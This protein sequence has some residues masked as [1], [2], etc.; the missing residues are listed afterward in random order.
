MAMELHHLQTNMRDVT[1]KAM[2]VAGN[3]IDEISR[4]RA[5][6]A[7]LKGDIKDLQDDRLSS[8]KLIDEKN[9]RIA[10]LED[11]VV[12]WKSKAKGEM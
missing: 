5:E 8:L 10:Q 9:A 2:D 11:D 7:E 4:L 3:A 6:N 1:Q 12:F